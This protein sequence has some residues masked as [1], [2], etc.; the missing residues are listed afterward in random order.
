M[1][2]LAGKQLQP[3]ELVSLTYDAGW[4]ESHNLV[5][6]VAV[7]LAES[8][9][10]TRASN[11]NLD[12]DKNVVSRDCGIYQINIP[13]AEIGTSK[14][15]ALYDPAFNVGVARNLFLARGFE[16]WVAFQSGVYKQPYYCTR[17][18]LGVMNWSL[19]DFGTVKVPVFTLAELR[20]K[21]LWA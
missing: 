6:A 21:K 11:D 1:G 15:E 7:C 19:V 17:A 10:Y 3:R 8:Q 18:A 12:A 20:A 2:V 5:T 13:A 4:K 14:E 9:G 16:P